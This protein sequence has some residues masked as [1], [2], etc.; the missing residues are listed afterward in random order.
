[1]RKLSTVAACIALRQSVCFMGLV[2][3][4]MVAA[5]GSS[6]QRRVAQ[7]P[8]ASW[9]T[10]PEVVARE[11]GGGGL[12]Q[13]ARLPV[14]DDAG[15]VIEFALIESLVDESGLKGALWAGLGMSL[16]GALIGVGLTAYDCNQPEGGSYIRCSPREDGMKSAVPAGLALTF[17]MLGVWLGW[18]SD[19]T[20]FQEAVDEI[21]AARRYGGPR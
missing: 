4:T 19:V 11:S 16:A 15:V 2:M 17:G 9:P 1:M 21:R 12:F 14:Y 20:T 5:A 8:L 3:A 6:A 18:N 10:V 7:P 13:A